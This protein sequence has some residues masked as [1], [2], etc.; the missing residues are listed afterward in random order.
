MLLVLMH[1]AAVWF[2]TGVIWTMQLLNYPL[3]ARV[4]TDSFT[5]YERG[6][7]ARFVRVVG[8]GAGATTLATIGLLLAK[9]AELDWAAP[10]AAA[11]LLGVVIVSTVVLQAPAHTRLADGFDANV[12]ARLVRTN[13][14]RTTAWTALAALD[15]WM[16]TQIR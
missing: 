11:V 14:I 9:P 1:A 8:P 13:W 3:L 12:H 2:M 7:N 4:G 16:I 15:L 10:I 5:D 6:H